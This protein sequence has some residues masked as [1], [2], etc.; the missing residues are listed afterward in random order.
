M[1]DNDVTL[2]IDGQSV[3]VAKGTNVLEAA[4]TIG[5]NISY[6]CYPPG[7][8]SP[9]GCRQCLVEVKGQPKLVPSCYTPVADNQEVFTQSEKTLLARQQ[10]LEFTLVNHP[11]D[12]PI[13][14]K[15]GEC[16]LQRLYF[17]HDRAPSRVDVEKVHKPKVVD[18]GPTVVLDSE[19]CILCSRC[20]RV[21]D[22]VAKDHQ[23]EFAFRGD[24]EILTVPP[25]QQL[26]N[27]N[28]L[29]VVEL[30]P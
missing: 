5:V 14:D 25:G 2:K 22:E 6:F 26:D 1:A 7:L 19:R 8:S 17:D 20:I 9:A 28:S 18:L 23:L 29:N 16:T 4:R 13:C 10:M 15:A 30:C 11:V 3:T 27:K 21:C 24:R 12:C